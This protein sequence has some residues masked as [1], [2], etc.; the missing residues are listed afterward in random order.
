MAQHARKVLN[1]V[2]EIIAIRE[3]A[4]IWESLLY[5]DGQAALGPIGI[6]RD[7]E[8]RI[9]TLSPLLNRRVLATYFSY[10]FF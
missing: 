5:I 1:I 4:A 7:N 9:I 10:L 2:N 6:T 3:K 8:A